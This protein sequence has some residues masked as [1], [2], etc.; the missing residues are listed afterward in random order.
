[1]HARRIMI[2]KYKILQNYLKSWCSSSGPQKIICLCIMFR[3]RCKVK[4]SHFLIPCSYADRVHLK[5]L[6]H[7]LYISE[8]EPFEDW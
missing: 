2:T 4:C 1:M 7:E 8:T 6:L 3:Q 5:L